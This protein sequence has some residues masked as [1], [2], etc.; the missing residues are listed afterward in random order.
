MM[1]RNVW[2]FFNIDNYQ[3]LKTKEN[4]ECM[5]KI[6]NIFEKYNKE[7]IYK[8]Q[9]GKKSWICKS[10]HEKK[11]AVVVFNC[12]LYH[13]HEIEGKSEAILFKLEM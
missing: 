7:N 13:P 1:V 2:G 5:G 11:P 12:T 8:C 4:I 9:M 10:L 6:L 3:I